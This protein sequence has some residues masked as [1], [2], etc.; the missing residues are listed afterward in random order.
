MIIFTHFQY[1]SAVSAIFY[2][3]VKCKIIDIVNL[4]VICWFQY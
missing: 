2:Q 3:K 4:S 1:F